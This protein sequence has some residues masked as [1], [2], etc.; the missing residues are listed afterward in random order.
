MERK[1]DLEKFFQIAPLAGS[2]CTVFVKNNCP[3][4][5]GIVIIEAGA[6]FFNKDGT[7]YFTGAMPVNLPSGAQD[8]LRS[9]DANKCVL[10][11]LGAVKITQPGQSEQIVTATGSVGPNECSIGINFILG[12]KY[13][14]LNDESQKT[15][16]LEVSE[17]VELKVKF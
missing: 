4:D 16:G 1:L 12:P 14:V 5:W 2:I 8:Q 17:L 9:I 7:D 13:F 10:T 6:R 3:P 15:L 11:V